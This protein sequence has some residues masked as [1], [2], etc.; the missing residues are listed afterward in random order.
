M[1]AMGKAQKKKKKKNPASHLPKDKILFWSKLNKKKKEKIWHFNL[2]TCLTHYLVPNNVLPKKSQHRKKYLY[3]GFFYV[4]KSMT[5]IISVIPK[6]I[7]SKD[8]TSEITTVP[9]CKL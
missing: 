2:F 8:H 6:N 5:V 4:L 1:H 7:F 3:R 9:M